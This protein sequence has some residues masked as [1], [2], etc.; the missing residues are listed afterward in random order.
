MAS[1]RHTSGGSRLAVAILVIA[2]TVW[3]LA[4]WAG[5]L[6]DGGGSPAQVTGALP[7]Q[8][9]WTYYNTSGNPAGGGDNILT[10]INPNGSAN[11]NLGNAAANTCA[12]IYVFDDDQEM[13]ECCGCPLSPAGIETFSVESDFTSN[14]GI[15]G[16]EGQD[17]S[18]GSIAIV[19]AGTNVPFT[20]TGPLSNGFFCPAAQSA[21]CNGGCDPTNSPGYSVSTVTNLLGS[22]VHNQAIRTGSGMVAIQSGLTETALFDNAGGDPTNLAYLQAQCGAVVGNGTGGGIC[23]CPR[24]DPDAAPSPIAT[25]TTNTLT[26][27]M[28]ACPI[29]TI[30]VPPTKKEFTL[31]GANPFGETVSVTGTVQIADQSGGVILKI[32]GD[33]E[34]DPTEVTFSRVVNTIA[35]MTG[36]VSF[37]K[38]CTS[39][40]PFGSND[41]TF[42][43]GESISESYQ[44]A[45]QE[46]ITSGKEVVDLKINNTIPFSFSCPVCG[47]DCTI[48]VPEQ[49]DDSTSLLQLLQFPFALINVVV[50]GLPPL[51]GNPATM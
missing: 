22:I 42:A 49:I 27:A 1:R 38:G 2:A 41:C 24:P 39:T 8:A 30:T 16:A 47:A 25:P 3:G 43:W 11:S 15:S 36:Q 10:L 12:M 29:E 5:S 26:F 9:L 31:P 35:H 46:N 50:P 17:N 51:F 20:P 28:P 33:A 4:A 23:R 13:G 6:R 14:W 32:S 44:G 48:T 7:G 18:N 19:A 21:A 34:A 45:L 37:D 40:D